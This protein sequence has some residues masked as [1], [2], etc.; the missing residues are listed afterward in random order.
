M[1]Q[2]TLK[3]DSKIPVANPVCNCCSSGLEDKERMDIWLVVQASPPVLWQDPA[4][5]PQHLHHRQLLRSRGLPFLLFP[6]LQSP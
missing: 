4:Q 5:T 3:L 1:N 6:L 2:E